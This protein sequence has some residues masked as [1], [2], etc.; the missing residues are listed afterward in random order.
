MRNIL[1]LHALGQGTFDSAE[2]RAYG[3]VENLIASDVLAGVPNREKSL[4]QLWEAANLLDAPEAEKSAE[5][6]AP[7]P[8]NS[9][10]DGE[11]ADGV[12]AEQPTND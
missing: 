6:E 12:V 4:T 8:I 5:N 9:R 1:L 10:E 7:S 2:V 11:G 3:S